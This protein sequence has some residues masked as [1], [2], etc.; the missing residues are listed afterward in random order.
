MVQNRPAAD[1]DGNGRGFRFGK[2]F[3]H[4][5]K[6]C[7]KWPVHT[8]M[9]SRVRCSNL[10]PLIGCTGAVGFAAMIVLLLPGRLQS[11]EA[12]K[13][14]SSNATT[15]ANQNESKAGTDPESAWKELEALQPPAEPKEWTGHEPTEEERR[16]F[17]KQRVEFACL[18]ADQARNFYTRFP[19]NDMAP[20]AMILERDQI[21][22]AFKIEVMEYRLGNLEREARKNRAGDEGLVLAEVEKGIRALLK[23]C[24]EHF[25]PN[26]ALL[27]RARQLGGIRGRELAQQVRDTK[28]I[29]DFV[30]EQAVELLKKLEAIG[31]PFALKFAAVD[32]RESK[33]PGMKCP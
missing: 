28:G 6:M 24:P 26:Q 21:V 11:A 20:M 8:N 25:V 12:G 2:F 7:E 22:G 14:D 4:V 5:K 30:K 1:F 3:A 33:T 29:P 9:L 10:G 13:P 15:P 32:G 23:E 19:S 16:E 27:K 18:L 31:K 17:Q